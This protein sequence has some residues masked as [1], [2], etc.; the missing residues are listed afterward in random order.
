[1]KINKPSLTSIQS[2]LYT[3]LCAKQVSF[4]GSCGR[5]ACQLEQGFLAL[6]V[7]L[8][9]L[10][11]VLK[12]SVSRLYLDGGSQASVLL[13][14]QAIPVGSLGLKQSKVSPPKTHTLVSLKLCCK[15]GLVTSSPG[16]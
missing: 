7:Q 3:S 16:I 14:L 5:T 9:L 2:D 1:M 10:A 15:N 8:N 13:K 11:E 4:L 12:I 6:A